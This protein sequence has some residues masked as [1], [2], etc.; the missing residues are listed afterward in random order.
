MDTSSTYT[1]GARI[2][3]MSASWPFA[4]LRLEPGR[5]SL[6]TSVFGDYTFTEETLTK[7]T[8]YTSIPF[9]GWGIHLHH[10][11]S[12]Y[13]KKIIFWCFIHPTRIVDQLRVVGFDP[14]KLPA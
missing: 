9:L 12:N 4:K 2:G 3:L 8:T 13:P 6:N 7:V 1:G 10:T 11:N 14:S 5:I